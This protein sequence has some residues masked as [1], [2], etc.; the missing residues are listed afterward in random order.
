MLDTFTTSQ[1]SCPRYEDLALALEGATLARGGALPQ[2]RP[3]TRLQIYDFDPGTLEVLLQRG[4]R[5]MQR[6]ERR[7]VEAVA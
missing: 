4:G 7:M 1:V 5:S 6:R 2:R 3:A